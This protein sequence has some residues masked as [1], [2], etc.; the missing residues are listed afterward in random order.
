MLRFSGSGQDCGIQSFI[1][2]REK[3]S[4][5]VPGVSPGVALVAILETSTRNPAE[6]RYGITGLQGSFFLSFIN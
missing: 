4:E 1:L 5:P 2:R 3:G 6:G